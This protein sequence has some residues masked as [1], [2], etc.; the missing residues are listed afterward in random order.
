MNE[1]DSNYEFPVI[2][3]GEEFDFEAIFGKQETPAPVP[4]LEPAA[5]EPIAVPVE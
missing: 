3:D 1:Y 5:E 4:V 2:D